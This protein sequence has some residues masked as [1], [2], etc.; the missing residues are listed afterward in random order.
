[1][2]V[3]RSATLGT[4]MAARKSRDSRST[5][6]GGVAPCTSTPCQVPLSAAGQPSSL[7]VGTSGKS[8]RRRGPVTAMGRNWPCLQKGAVAVAPLMINCASPE[9][10]A[11]SAAAPPR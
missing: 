2:V 3:M 4:A 5:M 6:A 7:K 11:V 10:T 9:A 1:M 8:G